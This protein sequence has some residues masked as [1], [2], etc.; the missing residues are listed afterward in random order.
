MVVR[1]QLQPDRRAADPWSIHDSE[2]HD[3]QAESFYF[4]ATQIF[5]NTPG[6]DKK[7]YADH[8][9]VAQQYK[10][11]HDHW[12]TY[13]DE[14]AKRGLFI[15]TAAP[16]YHGYTIG[17]NLNIYDFAEDPVLRRKAGMLLDLDFADYARAATP[18]HLGGAKSRSYPGDSYDGNLDSMT[19]IGNLVFGPGTSIGGD[20]HTLM[21]ATSGYMP[22]TVVQNL[23]TD[24]A[25]L[26]SFEDI[27]RAARATAR[28]GPTR[29]TTGT[30]QR[31][32]RRRLHVL[33]P[34]LH[35]G[36]DRAQSESDRA[37]EPSSQNRW[38]G[39]IFDTGGGMRG[40][41]AGRALQLHPRQRRVPFGT[42]QEHPR[43]RETR[44]TTTNP[45]SCTFPRASTPPP[46]RLD[47]RQ[48]GSGVLGR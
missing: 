23:A 25:G 27:T 29:R 33:H 20:N 7:K 45:P 6:Y 34:R 26:G 10:A 12:S 46:V 16:T 24:H 13:L 32:E 39:I 44:W 15:E 3:A 4:L 19:N 14:R 48:G 30:S 2:N 1:E 31:P 47:L 21:F 35:P 40:R 17:A 5:K 18:Q 8:T 36:H 22:P 41:S 37:S 28:S 11:W 43:D 38:Q 9:T 42:A